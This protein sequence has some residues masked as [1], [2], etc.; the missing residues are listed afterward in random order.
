MDYLTKTCLK[1]HQAMNGGVYR[2]THLCPHCFFE[3]DGGKKKRR[4]KSAAIAS[5]AD[6]LRNKIVQTEA[7]VAGATHEVAD[8][9]QVAASTRQ[10]AAGTMQVE[11]IYADEVEAAEEVAAAEPPPRVPVAPVVLTTKSLSEQTVLESLEEVTAECVLN[12]KVTPDLISNG[13][14]IGAKSEKVKAAL[15][16]GKRHVLSQLRQKAQGR[17]ANI[18]TDV[19][20]KN[21]VKTTDAQSVKII[22][23]ASGQAAVVEMAAEASEA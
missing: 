2:A 3:H 12:L 23:K 4:K 6:T 16:Q 14:F 5:D 15:E 10:V 8:V 7:V 1:C 9:G 21:A 19:S 17:G 22:V 11:E 13:K 18:V 20:V